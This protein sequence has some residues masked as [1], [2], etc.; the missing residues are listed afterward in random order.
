[1]NEYFQSGIQSY[2]TLNW[3]VINPSRFNYLSF[4]IL[5]LQEDA[6][7][8]ELLKCSY[9]NS[10]GLYDSWDGAIQTSYA[11][12]TTKYQVST[13]DV[14]YNF[15]T[16]IQSLQNKANYTHY[17]SCQNTSAPYNWYNCDPY[18]T[19]DRQYSYVVSGIISIN[20]IYV[21][22]VTYYWTRLY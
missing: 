6:Q 10:S 9:Y 20:Q 4:T 1:M 3:T 16:S 7:Y 2:I 11:Y 12:L 18:Y 8:L 21:Y 5:I 15:V 14:I 22:Y 13:G 19:W 17:Y